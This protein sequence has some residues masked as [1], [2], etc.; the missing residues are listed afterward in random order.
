MK[1]IVLAGGKGTRLYPL[2]ASISKQLMPIYDKPMI[3]YPIST[4][5]A[6]GIHDILII[7]TPS[8]LPLFQR[9]LGNGAQWGC[10]FTYAAQEQPKGLADAFLIAESFIGGGPVALILGDNLF[11]GI[12]L[13]NSLNRLQPL[14]GGH[15]FAY[16]VKDPQRYGVVQFDDQKK[17][18][19]IEEKPTRSISSYAV[20]GIYFYDTTVV[21]KAKALKPSARGELEITDINKAYLAEGALGVTPLD[22]GMVWLDTGTIES[23]TEA[24]QFVRALQ[25]RQGVL[26]G[27]PEMAAFS[28][29]LIDRAQLKQFANQLGETPYGQ[30]LLNHLENEIS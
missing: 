26:V 27:S 15:I 29:G 16:K 18:T 7:S 20:P 11:H 19:H 28:S 13:I 21:H 10:T 3:Y 14:K 6:A 5:L 25:S 4:L 24:S 2:T 17:V 23:L 8:D 22:S 30:T 12:H 9:L 1:G